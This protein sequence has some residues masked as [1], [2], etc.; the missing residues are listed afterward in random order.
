MRLASLPALLVG[1]IATLLVTSSAWAIAPG[2]TDPRKIMQA[3]DDRPDG[4]KMISRMSMVVRDAAGRERK[5]VV[6]SRAI[7]FKGGRRQIIFFESPADVRNTALLSIDYD[8]GNKD[9]DQWLYLPSL[10]KSTR[11]ASS[12]KSGSFMGTD[13]SY[14]DM[15]KQD[16]GHWDYKLLSPSVTVAG[17]E[18]WLIEA[19]PRTKKAQ[20]ET[21]YLKT[22]VWVSKQ[23]LMPLQ[24]KAWV[25]SGR[26]LKYMKFS[27][28]KQIEGIWLAH[29]SS[30][31][32]MRNTEV[33]STTVLAFTSIKLNDP[34]VK[35][36][37]FTQ[38]RLEQ[39]L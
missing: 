38:R 11:I 26:K 1:G 18:C 32:T 16:I 7:D 2:E 29:T 33:E 37:D 31:R 9:D 28:I 30:A 17:E 13:M 22:N 15:T 5:R 24:I 4:D 27:D 39:G 14:A 21:D 36:T 6:Q 34:S 12:D 25:R 8:D 23:K 19:R 20:D 35:D 3:V 10:K